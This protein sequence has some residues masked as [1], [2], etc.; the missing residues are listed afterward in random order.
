MLVQPHEY[1][2]TEH[3]NDQGNLPKTQHIINIAVKKGKLKNSGGHSQ[4]SQQAA[5][6]R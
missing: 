1:Q 6:R 4:T 5:Q 3:E 2:L